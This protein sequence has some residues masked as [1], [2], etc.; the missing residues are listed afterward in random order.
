MKQAIHQADLSPARLVWSKVMLWAMFT[1]IWWVPLTALL[2]V[3][4]A[5]STGQ[6]VSWRQITLLFLIGCAAHIYGY[7]LNDLRDIH[8]DR[9]AG[10]IHRALVTGEVS[11]ATARIVIAAQVPLMFLLTYSAGGLNGLSAILLVIVLLL[12]AAYNFCNKK[13]HPLFTDGLLAAALATCV[14][15]GASVIG[16]VSIVGLT[17]IVAFFVFVHTIFLTGIVATIKDLKTDQEVEARTTLRRLG[18][19]YEDGVIII[20]RRVYIV[21]AVYH[22]VLTVLMFAIPLW[23]A[24]QN[25][26]YPR[27]LLFSLSILVIVSLASAYMLFKV[28]VYRRWREHA[29]AAIIYTFATLGAIVFGLYPIV[30]NPV[31]LWTFGNTLMLAALVL[32]LRYRRLS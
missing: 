13:L 31:Q 30:S 12:V 9:R 7:V 14:V 27:R 10:K 29:V 32:V 22:L 17:G 28:F 25:L 16:E 21:A 15:F 5:F 19:R 2:F 26:L 23:S 3:W 20:P 6:L 11:P 24:A 1:R 18:A 4:G 8:Y